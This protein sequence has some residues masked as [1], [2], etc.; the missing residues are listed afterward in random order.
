MLLALVPIGLSRVMDQHH[1][2]AGCRDDLLN[3]SK[4]GPNLRL[5]VLVFSMEGYERVQNEDIDVLAFSN[6]GFDHGRIVQTDA[7]AERHAEVVIERLRVWLHKGRETV[8]QD[9]GSALLLHENHSL[10]SGSSCGRKPSHEPGLAALRCPDYQ[11]KATTKDERLDQPFDSWVAGGE[12]VR[13]SD[14]ERSAPPSGRAHHAAILPGRWRLARCREVAQVRG[15]HAALPCLRRRSWQRSPSVRCTAV[16]YFSPASSPCIA[17][18]TRV[19]S[20][21]RRATSSVQLP[22]M[23]P[24]TAGA[25]SS[26]SLDWVAALRKSSPPSA[27]SRKALLSRSCPCPSSICRPS[28]SANT[29]PPS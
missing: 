2:A 14:G 20:G 26:A 25:L 5:L 21:T 22:E 8:P 27:M 18:R 7:L 6:E 29:S 28:P 24:S 19:L 10:A 1:R 11:R 13:D 16:A 23:I 3:R 9:L 4:N 15:L 12:E 17:N